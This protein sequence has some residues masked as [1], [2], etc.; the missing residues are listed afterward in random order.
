MTR[1]GQTEEWHDKHPA[2]QDDPLAA[3][4]RL[5]TMLERALRLEA[6]HAGADDTIQAPMTRYIAGQLRMCIR[7]ALVPSWPAHGPVHVVLFRWTEN[8]QL[9][10][11]GERIF[12]RL[13]TNEQYITVRASATPMQ[14]SSSDPLGVAVATPEDVCQFHAR[15]HSHADRDARVELGGVEVS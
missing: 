6:G 14:T 1:D 15:A 10:I 2:R 3:C 12:L 5:I 7:P 9:A 8:P 4:D 13:P 11:A